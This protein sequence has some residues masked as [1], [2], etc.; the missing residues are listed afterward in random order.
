MAYGATMSGTWAVM[1]R[2]ALDCALLVRPD[3][4]VAWAT[5]T[6]PRPEAVRRAAAKWFATRVSET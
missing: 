4:F 6:T 1:P 2:I 3:G 5:D